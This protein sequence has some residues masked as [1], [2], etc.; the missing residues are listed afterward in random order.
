[1]GSRAGMT[2]KTKRKAFAMVAFLR[3]ELFLRFLSGFAIGAV[4]MVMLQPDET[5][6]FSSTAVAAT[7]A[8]AGAL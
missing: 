6:M 8:N 1:M 7:Q 3:S 5:P 2:G 4:G